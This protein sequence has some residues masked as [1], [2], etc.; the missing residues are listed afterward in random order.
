MLIKNTG[1]GVVYPRESEFFQT[2]DDKAENVLPLNATDFYNKDYL[3]L[4][5]LMD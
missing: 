2:L 4:K 1:D 3:G 5:T